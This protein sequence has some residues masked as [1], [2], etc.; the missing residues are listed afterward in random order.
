[1][2]LR[3]LGGAY[4]RVAE[5]ATAFAGRRAE[6]FLICAA[7]RAPGAPAEQISAAREIWAHAMAGVSVGCYGNFHP[8]RAPR[9]VEAMYP[10]STRERLREVKRSWDPDNVFRGNHN[11]TPR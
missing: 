8:T 9:V 1:M 4:G 2:M 7:F 3:T 5:D 11:V 6:A 10:P